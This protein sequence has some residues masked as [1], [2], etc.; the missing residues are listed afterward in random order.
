MED[1]MLQIE[2]EAEPV[3]SKLKQILLAEEI[4]EHEIFMSLNESDFKRLELN[5]KAIKI[6]QKIQKSVLSEQIIEEEY[7][8]NDDTDATAADEHPTE[9]NAMQCDEQ[10]NTEEH[11]DLE[12]NDDPNPYTGISLEREIDINIIFSKTE[13]GNDLIETLREAKKPNDKTIKRITHL[14]C[15][16]LKLN[17]GVRTSTYYKN[18]LAKSLVRSYPVLASSVS[19]V[20]HA[21]WFYLNG[22]GDGK[23]A[24]KI[25]YHM[26]YL[27][28][29]AEG[30]VFKRNAHK[31]EK[32]QS[33][34][35]EDA[36]VS[37]T[38]LFAMI[39]ELKFIVPVPE[40]RNRIIQLWES[41][42]A[43]RCQYRSN[44]DFMSFL[45][46]FPVSTA[47]HGELIE[48]DFKRMT[49]RNVVFTE[50]WAC[51]QHKVLHS[52]KYMFKEISDDFLRALAIIR[53]KNPTRGSKRL[54]NE[55]ASKENPLIG[56]FQWIKLDDPLPESFKNP[57]L[58]IRGTSM[59]PG[60]QCFISW[61]NVNIPV[62]SNIV[63]AFGILCQCFI[64]F[65]TTC[66]PTDKQ[67]LLFFKAVVF[68]T[69]SISTTGEKF[70]RS[71]ED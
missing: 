7:L 17:Y 61:N 16:F 5:T 9:V 32:E 13:E 10:P 58:A 46:E 71:L 4:D 67:F 1:I 33:V 43:I 28:K 50:E 36:C 45:E 69:S 39:E 29:R 57:V 35:H 38:D 31:M 40:N 63:Q 8:E 6:I 42:F 2:A 59:T 11:P 48:Y 3:R 18:M 37:E 24:G 65:G 52:Y 22:R 55:D 44:N 25:H 14:L 30:R 70:V 53:I 34:K 27:A 47:F 21:L 49:S 12:I 51:W 23:H 60:E 15:N 56:L 20:P 68:S 62:G 41:T 54:R 64:V 26:E 19:V 66:A